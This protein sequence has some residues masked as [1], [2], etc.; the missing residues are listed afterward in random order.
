MGR[1]GGR[2]KRGKRR[3][4]NGGEV[5][6]PFTTSTGKRAQAVWKVEDKPT[7]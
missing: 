3:G 5:E 6:G 2:G 4:G 1:R 7:E